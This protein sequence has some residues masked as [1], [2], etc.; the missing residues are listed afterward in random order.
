MRYLLIILLIFILTACMANPA[1][2]ATTT[3]TS[4]ALTASSQLSTEIPASPSLT[5]K[6]AIASAYPDLGPAPEIAG[7]VWLNTD[8]PLRLADLR[9]KVILIEMWTFDCI[10]CRN[11]IPSVRGWYEKYSAKGLVVIGNHFPEFS[12]ETDLNNLKQAIADLKVPYPVVQDNQGVNW[13]AYKNIY[14]PTLYLID[15]RGHIRY[16][17]IGEGAYAETE[18]AIQDLLKEPAPR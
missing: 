7:K 3:S 1:I 15:K 12:F 6:T 2:Q 10:N 18:A 17:H 14:W 16:Q 13:A 9:G 11:T 4:P 5:P 8:A